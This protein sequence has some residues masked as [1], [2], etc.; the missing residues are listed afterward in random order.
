MLAVGQYF[1]R[2]E[3]LVP[4]TWTG[5][6]ITGKRVFREHCIFFFKNEKKMLRFKT[7]MSCFHL[8]VCSQSCQ[9]YSWSCCWRTTVHTELF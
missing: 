5:I 8:A 7:V 2:T 6:V 4:Q 9:L 1:I 3:N